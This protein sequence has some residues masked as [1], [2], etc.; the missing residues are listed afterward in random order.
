MAAQVHLRFRLRFIGEIR[1]AG[2]AQLSQRRYV[3][4]YGDFVISSHDRGP[5]ITHRDMTRRLAGA[6]ARLDAASVEDISSR[7]SGTALTT[8]R[9]AGPAGE[10][11]GTM[12]NAEIGAL[13]VMIQLADGSLMFGDVDRAEET[14]LRRLVDVVNETGRCPVRGTGPRPRQCPSLG[15]QL[16]WPTAARSG[17]VGAN[18]ADALAAIGVPIDSGLSEAEFERIELTFGF[19]FGDDHRAMLRAGSRRSGALGVGGDIIYYGADLL[20]YLVREFGERWPDFPTTC[21]R[22]GRGRIPTCDL[23]CYLHL[24]DLLRVISV[25]HHEA[26]TQ[27]SGQVLDLL[28][29]GC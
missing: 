4:R 21:A 6:T 28:V 11:T 17:D 20:D 8:T 16:D 1:S 25:P 24:I 22:S 9:L 13:F 5:R 12:A 10:A 26:E 15:S 14:V 18:A 7:Q 23:T 27:P 2:K 29:Y 19:G 3:G